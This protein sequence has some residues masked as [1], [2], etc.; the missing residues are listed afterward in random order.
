MVVFDVLFAT[1][2]NLIVAVGLMIDLWVITLVVAICTLGT[3]IIIWYL[4]CYVMCL[5]GTI[6][7]QLE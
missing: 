2:S 3:G 7:Y 5:P 4:V 1:L 6:K